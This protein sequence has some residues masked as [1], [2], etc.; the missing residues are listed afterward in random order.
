MYKKAF[1]LIEML[2]VIA[3]I[4]ILATVVVVSYGNA[5]S[6]SRDTQRVSDLLAVQSAI[7][8]YYANNKVY[9]TTTESVMGSASECS[10]WGSQNGAGAEWVDVVK[11]ELVKYLPNWPRD[12]KNKNLTLGYYCYIYK[13]DGVDYALILQGSTTASENEIDWARHTELIDPYRDDGGSSDCTDPNST[14]NSEI[15]AWKVYSQNQGTG[16]KCW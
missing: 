14:N 7:T 13:S 4:G 5:Q 8:M 16:G 6:R 9:P 1:T 3:V 2:V 11:S 12:P 10:A 15:S